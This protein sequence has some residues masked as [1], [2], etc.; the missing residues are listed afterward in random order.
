LLEKGKC[1]A[2]QGLHQAKGYNVDGLS[3][4]APTHH[5]AKC[6]YRH[7]ARKSLG[8]RNKNTSTSAPTDSNHS[9]PVAA[10]LMP[11]CVQLITAKE[12]YIAWLP[13]TRAATRTTYT[14]VRWR[15][16]VS[17]GRCAISSGRLSTAGNAGTRLAARHSCHTSRAA[18]TE[19]GRTAVGRMQAS[20]ASAL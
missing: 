17:L 10:G 16:S 5:A 8:R 9:T 19:Q 15:S 2:V 1:E 7:G 6:R 18:R 11:A 20:A 12:S 4:N 14:K 3:E 13:R